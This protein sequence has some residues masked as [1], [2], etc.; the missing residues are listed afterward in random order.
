MAENT[1]ANG[2][3]VFVSPEDE[4][5]RRRPENPALLAGLVVTS[6]SL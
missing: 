2:K 6:T 5:R 4:P 3:T 1:E